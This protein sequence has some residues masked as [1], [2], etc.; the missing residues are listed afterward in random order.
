MQHALDTGEG[1]LL[2]RHLTRDRDWRM[3]RW[4]VRSDEGRV[5]ALAQ[6]HRA[7]EATI[8]RPEA[9]SRSK[10]SLAETLETMVRIVESKADGC[11]SSILLVESDG[12]HVSVAAGPSMPPE[13]NRAV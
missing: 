1:E 8:Y 3:L 11:R 10:S 5:V 12:E 9:P 7:N 2:A 6:S 4:R 13:Y